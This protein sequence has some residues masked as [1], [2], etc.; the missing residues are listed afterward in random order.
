MIQRHV[1][2]HPALIPRLDRILDDPGDIPH[3]F[4]AGGVGRDDV[5]QPIP[6]ALAG[7]HE[8]RGEVEAKVG[9]GGVD[10]GVD[11]VD[12]GGEL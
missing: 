1:P 3:E 12:G 5:N 8:D 7:E 6:E 9:G 2:I 11:A 10:D 4:L